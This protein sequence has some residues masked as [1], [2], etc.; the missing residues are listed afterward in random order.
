MA[1]RSKLRLR[2]AD[3]EVGSGGGQRAAA[4]AGTPFD[5]ERVWR[6]LT[7][8]SILGIF[9]ILAAW[10]LKEMASLLAPVGA[11]IL[12]GVVIGYLSDRLTRSSLPTL[13][14]ALALALVFCGAAYAMALAVAEPIGTLVREAP[15][16]AQRINGK[17]EQVMRPLQ[18]FGRA[19]PTA[20]AGERVVV[21]T[22]EPIAD[23]FAA[24]TPAFGQLVIFAGSL[25]FFLV[26]RAEF[27]RRLV[28][29]FSSRETRLAAL[30]AVVRVEERLGLYFATTTFVFLGVGAATAAMAWA[31]GLPAPLLWGVLAFLTSYVPFLGIAI[32]LVALGGY[33]LVDFESPFWGLAPA[34]AY[35]VIHGVEANLVTPAVLG[36]RMSVNAFALF[37]AIAF[38][39]WAWGAVGAFLAAPITVGALAVY[40]ELFAEP[41]PELPA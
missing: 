12:L 3:M 34:V 14:T 23:W 32:M 20:A 8:A 28:L 4:A 39:S 13:P 10:V 2:R 6:R 41:Q 26:G 24:L 17:I 27:K 30:K 40:D 31:F 15:E 29:T 25:L 22:R 36:R 37:L 38:W 7:Q 35:A 21:A 9:L 16:L 18:A 19:A 1:T 11:A 5:A 33:G